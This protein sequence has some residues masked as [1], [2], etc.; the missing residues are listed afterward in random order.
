MS[1]DPSASPIQ[2][3]S[4]KAGHLSKEFAATVISLV[5]T[6]LGVVLALAWNSALTGLFAEVIDS[7]GGKVVALFVYA[8]LV[9]IIGVIVIMSL[10][11]FAERIDAE[12]LE[13]KY[14]VKPKGEEQ[15]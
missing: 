5:T 7:P 15:E 10:S 1:K 3:V 9:T 6:A 4:K 13:F 12:P 8:I 11:R 2:H 14:P